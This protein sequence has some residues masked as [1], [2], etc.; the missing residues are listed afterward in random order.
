[1]T[2]EP[3]ESHRGWVLCIVGDRAEIEVE[4]EDDATSDTTIYE[5]PAEQLHKHDLQEGDDFYFEVHKGGV[6]KIV[7]VVYYGPWQEFES[8]TLEELDA[9]EEPW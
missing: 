7:P 9:L 2:E 5:L 1:M 8:L 3:L 4:F 6:G